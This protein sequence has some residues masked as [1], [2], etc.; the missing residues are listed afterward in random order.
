MLGANDFRQCA[1]KKLKIHIYIVLD[2]K[3]HMSV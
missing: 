3:L 1:K 2:N